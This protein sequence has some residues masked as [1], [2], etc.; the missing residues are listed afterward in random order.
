VD[1]SLRATI[2]ESLRKLNQDFGISILYIT[3]DLT[4]AYHI[5][6]D[7]LVLY[8]GSVAEA[9]EALTADWSY[10]EPSSGAGAVAIL[11]SE[12]PHVFQVDV[13]ANGYYGY[14][15]MD[16]CRP[17]P[18][19]EAGDADLSLLSYLDCCENAF[20][21]YQKRVTGVDYR[22]TFQY[23]TFHTP[24]GGM[25]KGA[26][27]TM[28][29]KMAKATP[30]EIEADFNERVM[31]GMI[32]CQRVGNIM[33]GTV[34]L[35]LASTV[36]KGRFDSPRRIGCFS[37]GSGC[38]SEFY[39]GIV[40]AQGQERQRRYGIERRLNERY[41]LSMNEYDTLLMGSGAVKFGTRNVKLDF[42]LIPGVLDSCKGKQRL[43]L[44]E[45]REFHREYRWVS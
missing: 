2:L 39:S 41:Q 29:R 37:Y 9:G 24:F 43:F 15:V 10:A 33:G 25:V 23:L 32:Y 18:D 21:E 4:T 42:E 35:S 13:G 45:I 7:I 17:A 12:S 5:G 30:P 6:H 31:P 14:E 26:H 38:C 27:R 1:A 16:T 40:T 34:F 22:G 8:R 19:S 3:H 28:M 36:D 44:E 11:V 20:L